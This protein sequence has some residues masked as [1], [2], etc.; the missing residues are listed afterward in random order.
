MIKLLVFDVDGTLYDL[1]RHE[2]PRSCREA[3]AQAKQNGLIFVIATGRTH[4]GLGAALNALNPDYILAVNGAVV[5]DG[6]GRILA[7]HDLSRGQVERVNAFC[8]SH[9]AGLAWKFLDHCYIYQHPEKIDWLQPQ[10]ESDIGPEPFIDCP[11]QDRHL[12]ALPQSASVHAEPE[13]VDEVFHADSELA[14]LRYSADGYDVVSRGMNKAVGLRE[15]I[16]QLKIAPEEVA[17]FGDNY[18]DVEMLKLA[19]TAV[20]MGNAVD[21]VKALADYVT[22]SSDQ[23]GI[24][25]AL[26]HRGCI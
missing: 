22:T 14:F 4:Y 24:A 12:S 7:H 20:A 19:G 13:A 5:A 8:R 26:A 15:L 9:Q 3:I 17:A 1:N 16:D 23:D 18:N 6:Q 21:E 2:I 25:R 10:K 11:T